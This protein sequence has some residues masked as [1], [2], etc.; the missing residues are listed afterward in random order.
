MKIDPFLSPCIKLKSKW[1]KDL[2][3]KPDTL[4]LI[5]KKLGKTLEKMGT[6]GKF[7]NR[8]PIAYTL[9]SIIDKWNLIKLQSFCKAKDTV[10]RTK[11][12]PTN[13]ERIF[14]NP[15]SDRGL[16]SNIYKERKK[17]E[18]REPNNPIKKM[19]YIYTMAYY[20][21]IRNNEFMKFLGKWMDLENI[22]LSEV[23]QTQKMNHLC[24]H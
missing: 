17:V 12:Q 21:A 16:I 11:R 7:L 2:R 8:T 4:K 3:I 6:G 1:I 9:R 5:E 24:T 23:T 13:W 15:I 22:I 10:K 18:L 19:W 14:T 20:T